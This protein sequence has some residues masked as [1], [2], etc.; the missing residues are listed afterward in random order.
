[1]SHEFRDRGRACQQANANRFAKAG[2][3]TWPNPVALPGATGT[4]HRAFRTEANRYTAEIR[5][6][7]FRHRIKRSPKSQ[8]ILMTAKADISWT[9][10]VVLSVARLWLTIRHPALILRFVRRLGYLPNPAAP[11]T[12]HERMLW[13]KIVDHNRLFV[14]LTDKLAA[15]AHIQKVCPD[16]KLPATLWSG[17][18]PADI[19]PALFDGD[20]VIK[21]NHGCAM[22]IFVSGG[23]PDRAAILHQTKRWLRKP[24]GRRDGE[25]AYWPIKPTVLIEEKL[26]LSGGRI[27]TDIK[28]HVCGGVVCHVWVEDQQADRSVLFDRNA[29]PLPGRDPDYPREDQA[30]PVNKRLVDFVREAIAIAPRL[31]AD[32]DYIRID[33]LV[34]DEQ[35]FASEIVVYTAAGYATWTNP[36]I[37]REIERHWHIEK[38][39]YMRRSHL[40]PAR[41]YA[42]ALLAK[43]M[44]DF[45]NDEALETACKD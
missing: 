22:N 19:P 18:D 15:K 45:N 5:L 11:E 27:A 21:V 41:L 39:D 30:L 38:S 31:A 36:D 13:R 42:E 10:R 23:S 3:R 43:C 1:M 24:F 12:Y 2:N 28:V 4:C 35:L 14:T 20:V 37:A 29:N 25:W 40:G 8:G 32:L 9:D 26:S 34:T 6:T 33:F 44:S 7:G 16:L 17:R